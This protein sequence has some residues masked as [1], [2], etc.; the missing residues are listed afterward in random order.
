MLDHRGPDADRPL[1]PPGPPAPGGLPFRRVATLV[2]AA[3]LFLGGL[4]GAVTFALD[5]SAREGLT[6]W[7]YGGTMLL[8]MLAAVPVAARRRALP[9]QALGLVLLAELVYAVVALCIDDPARY[10]GPLVLLLPVCAAAW[11]L[12]RWELGVVM[13]AT[14]VSC[15]VALAPSYDSALDL[16]VQVAI[17]A[18]V[19]DGAALGVFLLRRRVQRLLHETGALSRTDPLTGLFNRRY[20]VEQ[21]PRLWGQARRDGMHL[22][23]TVLDLDRF[24]QLNDAHGHA[25][26]D[27]VLQAVARSLAAT[28]RPADV[29]ARTGGEELV[30]LGVVSGRKEAGRLAERLRS[31]VADAR[32]ADGHRVTASVGLALVRPVDGEDVV[33]AL[34]RLVDHADAAMYAAKQAGG[35][36]V[37]P[38]RWPAVG[39]TRA[40]TVAEG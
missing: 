13:V 30:V 31:A 35:D 34:W 3:V 16:A 10:A 21:A 23:A 18:G 27:G 29:L 5:A 17:R 9:R 38:V 19:L 40:G 2:L 1:T 15:A 7:L 8:C 26:G 4:T 14:G 28:V 6:G 37:A 32:S 22:A 11:L 33:D 12:R 20:L 24:K 25:A 39:P 36:R